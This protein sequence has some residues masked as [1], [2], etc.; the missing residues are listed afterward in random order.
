LVITRVNW[1]ERAGLRA[2]QG[3]GQ[4]GARRGPAV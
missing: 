4:I 1:R 2:G 3:R